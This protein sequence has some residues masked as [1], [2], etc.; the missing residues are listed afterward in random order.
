MQHTSYTVA[1]FVAKNTSKGADGVEWDIVQDEL[2]GEVKRLDA[3]RK[4]IAE[5]VE[6]YQ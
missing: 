3:W 1:C 5:V 4:I 2:C 6:W